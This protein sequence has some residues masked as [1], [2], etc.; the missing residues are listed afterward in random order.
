MSEETPPLRR[1]I[2][3]R[4]P[5]TI[6]V[7]LLLVVPVLLVAVVL[8]VVAYAQAR[9]TANDLT[10]SLLTQVHDRI[11]TQIDSLMDTP[12]QIIAVNRALLDQGKLSLDDL[13]SWQPIIDAELRA[14]PS[15][16][17][18]V[19]GKTDGTAVWICR[20]AGDDD[21]IYFAINPPGEPTK[22]AEYRI[23]KQGNMQSEPS[24]VFTYDARTRPW[25]Q[26]GEGSEH[27]AWCEPFLFVGGS[28]SETVTLGISYAE[29]YHDAQGVMRGVLDVDLSLNDISHYLETLEIS[30]HG[31]VYIFDQHG[32]I[33][34]SSLGAKLADEDGKR[35]HVH[36]A[37]HRWIRT[38]SNNLHQ[39][40]GLQV[41]ANHCEIVEC[42]GENLLV[43]A[44]PYR[45]ATGINWT[46][47]VLIPESDFLANI[48]AAGHRAF[49]LTLG[50]VIGTVLIGL[51]LAV[52]MIRPMLR[53]SEHVRQIGQGDLDREIVLPHS[54][55]LLRLSKN[56]NA[57]TAGLRDRMRMRHSLA[58][59]M[60][61]QQ[62][63]LPAG[64][65]EIEGLDVAGHSTYCDETG[66]D[67]YDFLE[68]TDLS[69]RSV[70][71]A[72][73]DVMGHGV[74]AA[75]LMATA[76]GILRSQSTQPRSLADLL[77]HMNELLVPDT[78]GERFMTML[79]AVIDAQ[80][81][82][83]RWASAGHEPPFVYDPATDTYQELD[84]SGLPLGIMESE[85]YQEYEFNPVQT[86]QIFFMATDGVWEMQ[87]AQ[88]EQ[89]GKP[90]IREI[91]Q[92]N[93]TQDAE[94]ISELIRQQLHNFRGDNSQ[95]DDVTFVIVKVQ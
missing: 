47:V 85:H 79:L 39:T 7:P 9:L 53:L 54:P 58:T 46:V 13:R 1:T 77:E 89:F 2:F 82:I 38:T 27:G 35:I 61:V 25:Y 88:G 29:A 45:H 65:P 52:L 59:A 24:S 60:D 90:R 34:G 6:S 80:T 95:D 84:G 26:A 17:S 14:N 94:T 69:E 93:H 56:I 4:I 44:S 8:S 64:S 83:L 20:Y 40:R 92:S 71:V 87:N 28:D 21:Y 67:Y 12:A 51:L 16:S 86:G 73:G 78:G 11:D 32:L 55:E 74:A 50:V 66:G 72:L 15:I 36:E 18:V 37:A 31:E 30:D 75:M 41:Q 19:F 49:L 70:C 63:L 76:R 57:M 62:A 68:I 42:Y 5:L 81:G 22:M 91:I 48:N 10:E 3:S 43:M 23:D 33:I